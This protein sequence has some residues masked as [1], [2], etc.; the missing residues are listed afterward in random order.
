MDHSSGFLSGLGEEEVWQ[1]ELRVKQFPH[2]FQAPGLLEEDEGTFR[3]GGEAR[4]HN[5][6]AFFGS[7]FPDNGRTHQPPRH[8][9]HRIPRELA[10]ACEM[11]PSDGDP[12]QIFPRQCLQHH[13]RAGPRETLHLQGGLPE[14]SGKEVGTDRE[15]QRRD[16]QGE[17]HPPQ[18][19]GMDAKHP[20]GKDR[21]KPNTG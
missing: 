12:R 15:L 1:Y 19:A 16:R 5:G 13:N 9:C 20:A 3:R 7:R 21:G 11:H 14:L 10:F 8:R 2:E 17:E 4:G 6:D 18:G